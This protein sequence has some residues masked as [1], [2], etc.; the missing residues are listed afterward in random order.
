[1]SVCFPDRVCRIEEAADN[2]KKRPL[3]DAEDGDVEQ[4]RTRAE[5]DDGVSQP[6]CTSGT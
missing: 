2:D 3:E 5:E 4:K 6:E 1:M